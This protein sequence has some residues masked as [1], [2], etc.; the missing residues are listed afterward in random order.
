MLCHCYVNHILRLREP[1]SKKALVILNVRRLRVRLPSAGNV[2]QKFF[3]FYFPV[4]QKASGF[5]TDIIGAD[6]DP[7]LVYEGFG[8][9]AHAVSRN[10]DRASLRL[11]E[12]QDILFNVRLTVLLIQMHQIL[13]QYA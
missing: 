13:R 1:V 10:D 2:G 7:K 11:L 12:N 9:V 6:R 3:R 5:R 8:Q 4:I